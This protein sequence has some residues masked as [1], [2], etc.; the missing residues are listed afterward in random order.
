MAASNSYRA[1]P[2]HSRAHAS[3][4]GVVLKLL[5]LLMQ[6]EQQTMHTR[7]HGFAKLA[8]RKATNHTKNMNNININ[9]KVST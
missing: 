8:K 5:F 2:L 6:Q 9:T 7:M 4:C 1:C 3:A